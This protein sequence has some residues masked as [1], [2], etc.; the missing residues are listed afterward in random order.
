MTGGGVIGVEFAEAH[1]DWVTSVYMDKLG[2]QVAS[3]SMD[4]TVRLWN[5]K[6]TSINPNLE[7]KPDC[8]DGG[9]SAHPT[10]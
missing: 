4:K 2:T 1:D 5:A 7:A 6:A 10:S 9:S 8:T 3:S